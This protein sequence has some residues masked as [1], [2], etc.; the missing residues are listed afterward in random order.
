M[1]AFE[2]ARNTSLTP[3]QDEAAALQNYLD[4]WQLRLL[5]LLERIYP[6]KSTIS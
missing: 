1:A 5:G 4:A 2:I 3:T 6:H